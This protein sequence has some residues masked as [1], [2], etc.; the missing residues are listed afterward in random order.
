MTD[1]LERLKQRKLMQWAAAYVAGA[2]ALL[3]VLD[4]AA[5]SYDWPKLVMHLAFGAMVLGLVV[6]VLLAW[7]HGE[8][9]V[10]RVS[11]V[12][13]LLL[14]GV[15]AIGGFLLWREARVMSAPDASVDPART[16]SVAA[17]S[18]APAL[19]VPAKSIAV[20]PFANLS[21]DTSQQ[22]FSDG[23][24]E[25]LLNL[26]A[27]IPQLKV[28]AR[29]SSFWFRGKDFTIPQI[30]EK[31]RVAYILEGSVQKAGD[32]V[33]ISV[34]LVNA[35][36]DTQRWS[37]TYD[38]RLKDV[39]KI[40]DE[41]GAD[42]VKHLKLRLLGGAPKVRSID[43]RAYEL[44]LQ[45]RY[46]SNQ[47]TP[48]TL[49]RSDAML[50]QALAIDPRYATAWIGLAFNAMGENFL[51]LTPDRKVNNDIFDTIRGYANKARAIAPDDGGV[52]I[53]FGWMADVQGRT[54]EAAGYYQRAA[55]L[56]PAKAYVMNSVAF[57]LWRINRPQ[58]AIALYRA[59]ARLDPV[60][61]AAPSNMINPLMQLGRYDDVIAEARK[62]L[63]L[64]PDSA[65]TH[66]SIAWA[67]LG[68]GEFEAALAEMHKEPSRNY[69]LTIKASLYCKLGRRAEAQ[70]VIADLQAHYA[71]DFSTT[72]ASAYADCGDPDQAF[73]W[74]NIA[75]SSPNAGIIYVVYGMSFKPYHA[76]PRWKAFLRKTGYDPDQLAKIR[77]DMKLPSL[78]A[79]SSDAAADSP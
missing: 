70:R 74:L 64:A 49:K 4:L 77:F 45:A 26:L 38:R 28:T 78:H 57:F 44:F 13:L 21:G 66:A 69:R 35:A 63:Q 75:A 10:Q 2:W 3:Q 72:I 60:D 6:T 47:N 41:I 1:F 76:D 51:A 5:D 12:E 8:R 36:T 20:L 34:Q 79:E 15:F 30:A 31:L 46:L 52:Q 29:T 61:A 56:A 22:Y 59:E 40:Q 19:P 53:L 32:E 17:T 71:D 25:D 68:K 9:G 42:V 18:T 50:H 67:L 54:Q 43:P 23:I 11:G 16:A 73:K 14:A 55:Q 39:F 62:V 58:Q 33:R 37:Q 7:Y 65:G 48:Q 24:S 27:R